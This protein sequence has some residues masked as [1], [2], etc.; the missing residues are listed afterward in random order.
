M[1]T[2]H[3]TA[4]NTLKKVKFQHPKSVYDHFQ[5]ALHR[6]KA[7]LSYECNGLLHNIWALKACEH[8]DAMYECCVN[9]LLDSLCIE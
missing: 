1:H 6:E 5:D 7:P 9:L 3:C 4:K 2:K 8:R